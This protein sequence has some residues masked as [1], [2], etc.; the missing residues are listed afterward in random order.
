MASLGDFG[1]HCK[2]ND[3]HPR[4]KD[5]VFGYVRRQ[6]EEFG[7][8]S[9]WP[10]VLNYMIILLTFIEKEKLKLN[11]YSLKILNETIKKINIHPTRLSFTGDRSNPQWVTIRGNKLINCNVSKSIYH[12]VISIWHECRCDLASCVVGISNIKSKEL[13][14]ELSCQSFASMTRSD[15][16]KW[17]SDYYYCISNDGLK[18]RK[19][20]DEYI[21]KTRYKNDF[22]TWKSDT[23]IKLQFDCSH[24]KQ[25]K[26][27]YWINGAHSYYANF[28]NIK[29]YNTV[30][31]S[32]NI[33][34]LCVSMLVCGHN[35]IGLKSYIEY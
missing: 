9:V 24:G 12:W 27:K 11:K 31:K 19:E 18:Y 35:V 8:K 20:G 34:T 7:M 26:L 16:G 15:N 23:T 13:E 21:D 25:K 22:S 10:V 2:I 5:C 4:D 32:P 3:I 1:I 28:N 14:Q 30:T 29:I 6:T 33:Y 17:A